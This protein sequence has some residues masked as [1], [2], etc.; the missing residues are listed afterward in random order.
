VAARLAKRVA[1]SASSRARWDF[2][3]DGGDDAT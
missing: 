3:S 1:A 2:E